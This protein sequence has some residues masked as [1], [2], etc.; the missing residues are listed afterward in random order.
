LA[1]NENCTFNQTIFSPQL[2]QNAPAPLG[3]PQL[4]QNFFGEDDDD[5]NDELDDLEG[6]EGFVLT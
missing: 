5:E 4:E 2:L 6:F 3:V 1:N